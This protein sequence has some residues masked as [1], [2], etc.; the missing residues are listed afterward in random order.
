[1]QLAVEVEQEVSEVMDHLHVIQ[2]IQVHNIKEELV[3]Q[4]QV[5]GQVIAQ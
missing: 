4:D 1:M 3:E 5:H 2:L